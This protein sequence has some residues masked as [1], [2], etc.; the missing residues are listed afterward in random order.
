MTAPRESPLLHAI[1][2]AL[3]REPGVTIWRNNVG[4]DTSRGVRYGLGV[5]SADLVGLVVVHCP[6]CNAPHSSPAC[7]SGL[8]ARALG[9]FFALEV[10]TAAGRLSREQKIWQGAVTHAGGFSAVVRSVDEA[11]AALERARRGEAA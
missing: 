5:G 11:L 4:V 1:R 8:H 3:A 10:K 9:R 2:A 6:T 7:L